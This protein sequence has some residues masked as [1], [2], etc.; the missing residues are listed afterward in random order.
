MYA[1][2]AEQGALEATIQN[3]I[4]HFITM[5]HT[6]ATAV[7]LMLTLYSYPYRRYYDNLSKQYVTATVQD[8]VPPSTLADY[9]NEMMVINYINIRSIVLSKNVVILPSDYIPKI[10]PSLFEAPDPFDDIDVI[11]DMSEGLGVTDV[12]PR[13]HNDAANL[14]LTV[15]PDGTVGVNI[16]ILP[17][18]I[19][20]S[21]QS[22]TASTQSTRS[23][24]SKTSHG[25]IHADMSD[26][27]TNVNTP[28]SFPTAPVINVEQ[29]ES[30][31]FNQT[32]FGQYDTEVIDY[33][34]HID[35]G[36]DE[37]V[38]SG[39][40]HPTDDLAGPLD[41]S[42][43]CTVANIDA[44]SFLDDGEVIIDGDEDS[45]VDIWGTPVEPFRPITPTEPKRTPKKPSTTP[46]VSG[47]TG[48]S[49]TM[50]SGVESRPLSRPPAIPPLVNTPTTIIP[51]IDTSRDGYT[52]TKVNTVSQPFFSSFI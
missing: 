34:H 29:Y 35:V 36:L 26:T 43:D 50:T 11:S 49:M 27:D 14:T 15:N 5:K 47:T 42:N 7:D 44:T 37:R 22:S 30:I 32:T 9:L 31:L 45:D 33:D 4:T 12:S 48:A 17:D 8:I 52:I 46:K 13:P 28:Y 10:H 6:F 2:Y 19:E 25:S 51:P 41:E 24:T 3:A 40:D 20:T 18:N 39:F 23:S 16:D 38:T 21:S 1:N